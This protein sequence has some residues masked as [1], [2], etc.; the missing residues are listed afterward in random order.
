MTET[1]SGTA[2][3]GGI[4][5]LTAIGAATGGPQCLK[6]VLGAVERT[7]ATPPV[8]VVQH[9]S[10]ELMDSFVTWL[11]SVIALPVKLA[12]HGEALQA[13]QVYVAPGDQYLR[14][15]AELRV[16]LVDEAPRHG[17]RASIDVCFES[18]AEHVGPG[19]LA[20]L[21]TG[22]GRDGA[23][24]LL[25]IKEAG[26]QALAQDEASSIVYGMPKAAYELAAVSR[27]TSLAAIAHQLASIRLGLP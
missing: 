20:V 11:G 6:R 2:R 9:M 13:G 18:V 7:Q 24:G 17:R 12:E 22:M 23:E 1:A 10:V 27:G 19:A 3:S 5:R 16:R 14:I 8:L 4:A 25:K 26:G 15:D 21:L